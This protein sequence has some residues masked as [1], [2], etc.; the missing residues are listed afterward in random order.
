MINPTPKRSTKMWTG[1]EMLAHHLRWL[2]K[3]QTA[4]RKGQKRHLVLQRYMMSPAPW[5]CSV[6][7]VLECR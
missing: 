3:R 2:W 5:M 1:P 4:E 6:G 7:V